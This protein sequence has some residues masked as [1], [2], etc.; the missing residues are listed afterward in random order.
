MVFLAIIILMLEGFQMNHDWRDYFM[1]VFNY[2]ELLGNVLVILTRMDFFYEAS[3]IMILL[4]LLRAILTLQI[5]ESF[6]TLIKMITQS[7]AR[8]IPFLIVVA[9]FVFTFAIAQLS[10][11]R[12]ERSYTLKF[13]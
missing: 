12:D 13:P 1:D 8:M 7:I 3:W 6:R 2:P 4:I 9:L 5:I 10:V 11:D